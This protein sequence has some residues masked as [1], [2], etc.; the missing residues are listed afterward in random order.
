MGLQMAKGSTGE[1]IE[2][3]GTS[4]TEQDGT[5]RNGPD[6]MIIEKFKFFYLRRNKAENQLIGFG[7]NEK[8]II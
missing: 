3:F 5:G 1:F 2:G 4:R 8:W 7:G 6:W